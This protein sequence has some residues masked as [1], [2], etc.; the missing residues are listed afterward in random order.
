MPSVFYKDSLIVW[1]ISTT[2]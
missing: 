2:T 1:L